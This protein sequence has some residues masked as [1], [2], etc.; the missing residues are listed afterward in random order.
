[1]E[2]VLLILRRVLLIRLD[3]ELAHVQHLNWACH[4]VVKDS[5]L[6]EHCVLYCGIHACVV[7]IHGYFRCIQDFVDS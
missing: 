7:D 3:L 4:S 2:E 1:M 6:V 5:Y